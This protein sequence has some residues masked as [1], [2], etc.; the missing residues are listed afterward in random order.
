MLTPEQQVATKQGSE[1]QRTAR[2]RLRAWMEKTFGS[3]FM[4]DVE[5]RVAAGENCGP[6]NF[7]A[8]MRKLIVPIS[9]GDTC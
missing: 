7:P 1:A 4:R 6:E 2:L 9:R 5:G 3:E 8:L